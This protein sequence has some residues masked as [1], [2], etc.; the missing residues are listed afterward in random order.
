MLRKGI[1]R[2]RVTT[3]YQVLAVSALQDAPFHQ[4]KTHINGEKPQYLLN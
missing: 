4:L 1:E 2:E 3:T